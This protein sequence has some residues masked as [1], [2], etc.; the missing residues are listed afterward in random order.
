MVRGTLSNW[1][2]TPLGAY[3]LARELGFCDEVVADIFGF[4]ALQLGN[5]QIDFLRASRMPL[6]FTVGPEA[7]ASSEVRLDPT[8][9]E[10][11]VDADAARG[12]R[13][14]GQA[15]VDT[16]GNGEI[17][18]HLH[19]N[20]QAP[21]HE[22]G[23]GQIPAHVRGN[24]HL[25]AH[26]RGRGT[27]LPIATQSMDLV[28]LPHVLE[29]AADPHQILREVD[30]VM[31]PEGRL[32]VIGFNPWSLWGLR[33]ALGRRGEDHPWCGDFISMVRLKDWLALLGFDV[34][35]GRLVCYVPPMANERWLKRFSFME[36]A[37]DRWWGIAGGVYM[38]QAI[39]RV[40]GMRL[41]TPR[42]KERRLGE[43]AVAPLSRRGGTREA[44]GPGRPSNVI[45]LPRKK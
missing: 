16:D 9:A 40:Q 19:G 18:A 24:G 14:N 13:G 34:S 44:A 45:A 15:P 36:A 35:A 31:M 11:A 1:F 28:L 32:I 41:I 33:Q 27:E 6:R 26:V 43:Q 21:A 20:G 29:F 30:R 10:Q 2:A 7:A 38:M 5:A 8:D 37:G 12:L 17:P 42:W 25:P 4:N 3:V 23:N 22:R 39:K